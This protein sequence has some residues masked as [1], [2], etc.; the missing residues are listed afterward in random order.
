MA[1]IERTSQVA[2]K[3]SEFVVNASD[4]TLIKDLIGPK[5]EEKYPEWVDLLDSL[6][7]ETYDLNLITTSLR[8]V[9]RG[10]IPTIGEVRK[11]NEK[12]LSKINHVGPIRAAF[13]SRVF[14]PKNIDKI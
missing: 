7:L 9:V 13:L 12:Q 10:K 8:A 4:D 11:R 5:A 1:E 14:A 3:L 6:N 2:D